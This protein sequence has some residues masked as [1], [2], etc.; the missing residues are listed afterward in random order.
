MKPIKAERD[1]CT[2]ERWSFVRVRLGRTF[3]GE[4][5]YATWKRYSGTL[6][7]GE[8]VA[9]ILKRTKKEVK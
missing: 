9:F 3:L 2:T 8:T 1:Y 6:K 5:S 7:P 4:I